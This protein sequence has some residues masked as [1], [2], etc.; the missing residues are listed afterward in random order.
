MSALICFLNLCSNAL[1]RGNI[2]QL[3]FFFFREL[4]K[5]HTLRPLLVG[6]AERL[7]PNFFDLFLVLFVPHTM[8]MKKKIILFDIDH[9]L[10]DGERYKKAMF[11]SLA[12][13]S[14]HPKRELFA[15]VIETMYYD[16]RKRGGFIPDAFAKEM[17]ETH[18]LAV[19]SE[20]LVLAIHDEALVT[21]SLFEEVHGIL[22]LLGGRDDVLLG[23]FS[24]GFYTFQTLKIKLV[25]H[26][27]EE[28]HIHIFEAKEKEME[29]V[30]EKYK[31]HEI[32]LL[33]DTLPILQKAKLLNPE[34]KTVWVKR[35]WIALK[36]K[37]IEGFM[38]DFEV[39]TLKEAVEHII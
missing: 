38:A 32:F 33:D 34:V 7:Y 16:M 1:H 37:P 4:L 11:L 17:I 12:K 5:Q 36:Q 31:G 15:E 27:F 25:K 26:F 9:T 28:E 10:F 19:G 21:S 30:L 6:L 24:T 35:G 8:N 3:L 18:S 13:V 20:E 29:S 23:I 14:R 2:T 39:L 22:E